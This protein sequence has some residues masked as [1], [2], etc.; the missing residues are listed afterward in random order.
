MKDGPKSNSS[1]KRTH[2]RTHSF[3]L[4]KEVRKKSVEVYKVYQQVEKKDGKVP[5]K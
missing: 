4:K 3:I 1:F 2:P 5:E